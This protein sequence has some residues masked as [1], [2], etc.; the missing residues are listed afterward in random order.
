MTRALL[1]LASCL[2]AFALAHPLAAQPLR[3]APRPVRRYPPPP[4]A[5][6]ALE[7]T[8]PPAAE[9]EW[10]GGYTLATFGG[11]LLLGLGISAGGAP[12]FGVPLGAAGL[13]FAGPISHWA[14]EGT[15]AGFRILAINVGAVVGAGLTGTAVYCMVERCRS[16]RI[17]N[18]FAFGGI[19]G[20]TAGALIA[21]IVDVAAMS[22]VTPAPTRRR[23]ATLLVPDLRVSADGA[24]LGL[25]GVF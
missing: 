3:S 8:E 16:S 12:Q 15:G 7:A 20:G 18:A 4:P 21:L 1:A 9:R 2:G 25:G 24:S 13:L 22:F 23:G 14:V 6:V 10:F 11:T 19:V 5:P 17:D